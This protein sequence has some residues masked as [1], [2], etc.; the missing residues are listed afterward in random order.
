VYPPAFFLRSG[1]RRS[2]VR[3]EAKD[4][5]G[6]IQLAGQIPAARPGCVE[7]RTLR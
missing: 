2:G 3:V 1:A 7:V 5:K 6:A 4:L